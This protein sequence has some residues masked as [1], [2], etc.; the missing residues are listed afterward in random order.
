MNAASQ[1]GRQ[2]V[3]GG[4]GW[5]LHLCPRV[6]QRPSLTLDQLR[7]HLPRADRQLEGRGRGGPPITRYSRGTTPA[8]MSSSRSACLKNADYHPSCQNM[9][10][11]ASVVT[12]SGRT[13]AAWLR[14]RSLREGRSRGARQ[15][16]RQE[17]R[18]DA[19]TRQ[20]PQRLL[21]DLA[22]SVSVMSSECRR[23]MAAKMIKWGCLPK[24]RP[25][26][27]KVGYIPVK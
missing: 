6:Q 5:N 16:G 7:R 17:Q 10:G 8:R 22:L 24:G 4:K 1:P 13:G 9:P 3:Q 27:S 2:R 15:E 11:T 23:A 12:P 20:H 19:D 25:V 18:G 14:R 21:S 26:V